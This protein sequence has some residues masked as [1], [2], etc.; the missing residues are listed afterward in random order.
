MERAI[1][2]VR[3]RFFAARA[4]TDLADLNAQARAWCTG[5]AAER[6]CPEDRTRSV[7]QCFEEEQPRLLHLPENPFPCEERAIVRTH[8]TPYARF[9][10]NDYSVPHTHVRRTLEVRATL[11][12][13]QILDGTEVIAVHAR[14]FDRGVQIEN[15]QHIQALVDDKRAGRAHRAMDR[16]HHA[17]P[18]VTAFFVRAAAH[19]IHL[20]SLTR[21]LLELLE[22]HGAAALEAALRAALREGITHLASVRPHPLADYEPQSLRDPQ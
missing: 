12:T 11:E 22:T 8:K 21:G 16:L 1:R 10:L 17:T 4:F 7:R 9:D 15:P 13:V 2:F 5:E 19:G 20:A 18:S 6:P 3:D 14:R